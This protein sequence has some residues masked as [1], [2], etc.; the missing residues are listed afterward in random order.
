MYLCNCTKCHE[1]FDC[2]YHCLVLQVKPTRASGFVS[3]FMSKAMIRSS[4]ERLSLFAHDLLASHSTF[5]VLACGLPHP[6][7]ALAQRKPTR[8]L[9]C[10]P[11][12][13]PP[14]DFHTSYPACPSLPCRQQPDVCEPSHSTYTRHAIPPHLPEGDFAPFFGG[15]GV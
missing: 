15:V 5:A 7:S 11:S 12:Y 10:T 4:R 2:K 6:T 3:H 1:W 14:P 13:R 9:H 8:L